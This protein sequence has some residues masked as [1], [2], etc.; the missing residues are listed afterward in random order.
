[1][2]VIELQTPHAAQARIIAEHKRFNVVA[3]GRRFGKSTLGMDQLIHPAL[4]GRPV[5]WFSPTYKMLIPIWRE[6]IST[7]HSV[8]TRLSDAEHRLELCGGGVV[9]AWSLDN[10]DAGRGRAYS[11][12]VIDEAAMVAGLEQAW[13]QS[14]RP[15][16][17][18]F[19]GE[20]WFLSTPRGVANFFHVL[21]QKGAS[22]E[23]NWASWS[24][25]TSANPAIDPSEIEEARRDSPELSFAQ[26][27]LAQFVSWEGA[28]FRKI[29]DAVTDSPQGKGASI[30]CDWGRTNDFTVF[31]VISDCGHVLELDRF[32]GI[33]YALQRAR[34]EALWRRHGCPLIIAEKNA[35]GGP[36]CEQ[37]RHDGLKVRAFTT[38]SQS[39]ADIIE[40]LSLAFERG[41]IRIPNHPVLIGELQ[42][43]E[44]VPMSGG[45]M[46]KYGAPSGC[47]DDTVMSLALALHGLGRAAKQSALEAIRW[48][49][50]N[51]A[52]SAPSGWRM[53]GEADDGGERLRVLHQRWTH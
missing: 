49:A 8:T 17:T 34:L 35:M 27:Y 15:T 7:L 12:V 2:P 32:R 37:L 21:H 38:T 52:L 41:E 14:I 36:I 25:A 40:A 45:A 6:L 26:E 29:L 13:T 9:E 18:D 19:R 46:M 10:L 51:E 28:V 20:A 23:P 50:A 44:G 42:S 4:K 22:G 33:E 11:A 24:M 5:G 47:H 3:C 53:E 31:T 48:S 1:M 43:F 39:K 16:L 30:G